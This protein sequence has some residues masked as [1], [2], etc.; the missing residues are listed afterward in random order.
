MEPWHFFG[1]NANV[2][3]LGAVLVDGGAA[4]TVC[5]IAMAVNIVLGLIE[6]WGD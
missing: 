4:E 3:G 2:W 5:V 6:L 1:I